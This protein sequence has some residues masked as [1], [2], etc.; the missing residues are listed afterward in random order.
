MIQK[1]TVDYD[2]VIIYNL[3]VRFVDI[4]AEYLQESFHCDKKRYCRIERQRFHWPKLRSEIYA[5]CWSRFAPVI[6]D[7]GK[8]MS[9]IRGE[10]SVSGIRSS[11]SSE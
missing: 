10:D 4:Q 9:V 7:V 3:W 5:A 2:E 6:I 8:F 1:Q 11:I